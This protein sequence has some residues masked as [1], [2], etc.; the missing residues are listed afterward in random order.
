M[1]KR[2][3]KRFVVMT[4]F[5]QLV[6]SPLF[7]AD[8]LLAQFPQILPLDSRDGR[9]LHSFQTRPS[10]L[11]TITIEGTY[12][13]WPQYDARGVDACYVY[14]VPAAILAELKW[15]PTSLLP[16]PVWVGNPTTFPLV[17]YRVVDFVGLRVNDAPLPDAGFILGMHRY[18]MIVPGTG[19]NFTFQ[20][21][22]SAYSLS[23]GRVQPRYEDN[24]GALLV[25]IEENPPSNICDVEPICIGGRV[26][27]IQLSASILDPTGT[28]QL[29]DLSQV[30]LAING[31]FI[32]PDSMN[33]AEDF[34]TPSVYALILDKSASMNE[35][36]GDGTRISAQNRAAKAFLS[37]LSSSALVSVIT[38]DGSHYLI[39]PPT[40]DRKILAE[41][42]DGISA[43]GVTAM[44]DAS[45]SAI[46]ELRQYDA[47]TKAIILIS[48][49]EDNNSLL[50]ER[51]VLDMAQQDRIPIYTVGVSLYR[52]AKEQLKRLASGTGGRY[53]EPKNAVEL[54]A[55]MG[56]LPG[57]INPGHCCDLYFTLPEGLIDPDTDTEIMLLLIG[58]DRE[59]LR[60]DL[61]I[62]IPDSCMH[63]MAQSS[64]PPSVRKIAP[65]SLSIHPNPAS[66][67]ATLTF[68]ARED[69]AASLRL[70]G[71][72]GEILHVKDLPLQAGETK[73][74]T[75]DLKGYPSSVLHAWV[76]LGGS[77]SLYR[78]LHL[79]K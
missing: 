68:V 64:V 7:L 21:L 3:L 2:H 8:S 9:V 39:V 25:T 4:A 61:I 27:G 32:C 1:E 37:G 51:E 36:W 48:D 57:A 19:D 75:V 38:F 29:R 26:R 71:P 6:F 76:S 72:K 58:P 45:A 49:G 33:C 23:E 22:D 77:G 20:I 52:D 24:S 62:R 12:S 65:V 69:L 70:V 46:A 73:E 41:A 50:A 15:P 79:V 17:P 60:E 74:I 5:V 10:V 16:L 47:M 11:Y 56:N 42:I 13:M 55:T 40:S 34:L 67:L 28:N 43:G 30:S 31:Q 44:Y 78:K 66:D 59:L 35:A 14:D 63:S 54:V 53:Y 18:Q